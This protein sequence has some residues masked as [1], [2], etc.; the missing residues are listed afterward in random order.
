MFVTA[1]YKVFV[2]WT[3]SCTGKKK[4]LWKFTSGFNEHQILNFERSLSLSPGLKNNLFP[5]CKI[6]LGGPVYINTLPS[7]FNIYLYSHTAKYIG[8]EKNN[9]I[10]IT[11]L[12]YL[13]HT[14]RRNNKTRLFTIYRQA[15]NLVN[16]KTFYGSLI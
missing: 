7:Y 12:D 10:I 2:I 14:D 15:G 16:D 11:K 5:P 4:H 9:K 1:L 6:S 13:L 3:F 8:T